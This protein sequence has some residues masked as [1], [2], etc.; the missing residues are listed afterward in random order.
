ME[1][2]G[3]QV[4][5]DDTDAGDADH[6]QGGAP[7]EDRQEPGC[8]YTGQQVGEPHQH[9]GSETISDLVKVGLLIHM[10][11]DDLKDTILQHADRLREY[12]LVKEKAVNL[13]DARALLR[14]P[15]AMDVEYYGYHEEDEYGQEA[16]ETEVGAVAEDMKYFSH[17]GFGHREKQCATP[18]KG[19]STG[20]G[21]DDTKGKGKGFKVGGKGQ[22]G[23]HPC[24]R[25]GKTG[26]G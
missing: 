14:D 23:G 17:V 19:K 6:A 20:K 22:G 9:L 25:C 8:A 24:G 21:R 7:S 2:V 26:H 4:H 18:P 10:M 5:S 13:V 15:S 12:R 11:P 3:P 1:E 16:E